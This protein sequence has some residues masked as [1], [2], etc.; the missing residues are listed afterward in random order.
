LYDNEDTQESN[1]TIRQNL[2]S[3]FD[4]TPLKA[5]R[6]DPPRTL[7]MTTQSNDSRV[8]RQE[9]DL[10]SAECMSLKAS[11]TNLEKSLSAA[12]LA[13]RE[14]TI[15]HER[16]L[17]KM[18]SEREREVAK[19]QEIR[20]KL[21]YV[22]E[23]ERHARE[24]IVELEIEMAAEK[25]NLDRKVM[26]AQRI[27]REAEDHAQ[28]QKDSWHETESSLH[29]Q[30]VAQKKELISVNSLYGESQAQ[31][32]LRGQRD[33]G[34]AVHLQ[35]VD[36]L[37]TQLKAAQDRA[38]ALESQLTDHEDNL[39]VTK[40]LKADLDLV[41]QM[42][43][44]LERLRLDNE[45]LKYNEQNC[46]LLEEEVRSL[47]GRLERAEDDNKQVVEL[48][49]ENE[50]LKGRL[51]RWEA[52]DESGSR[53]PQSPSSLSRRATDLETTI[54]VLTVQ[55]GELQTQINSARLRQQ[56][57]QSELHKLT[58]NLEQERSSK[59]Q[60]TE[61][62]K[63]LKRKVLFLSKERDCFKELVNSYESELTINVDAQKQVLWDKQEDILQDYRKQVMELETE[64]GKLEA[65]LADMHG[66]LSQQKLKPSASHPDNA[67][68]MTDLR[69]AQGKTA[70]V[71]LLLSK[72]QEE[73]SVLELRL[74]QRHL[75]GDFDPSKTK[76]LH[77]SFNPAAVAQER[78]E[79]ELET[80]RKEVETL[81]K[82]AQLLEENGGAAQDLTMQVEE[83][84][85]QPSPSKEL[86]E[87]KEKLHTEELRNK[88]L[89]E[90]FKKTSSEFREVCYQLTGYK[91]DI[92]CTNQYRLTNMYSESSRDHLLFQQKDGRIQV[93][94]TDYSSRL[95]ESLE[96]YL[97]RHNSI[98]ALLSS[99]TM[100]LFSQV[101]MLA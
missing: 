8:M 50:E 80:L 78:R 19:N 17:W 65:S 13:T 82:R 34:Q 61:L 91:I 87:I 5:R 85:L 68:L 53:R 41:P 45:Q 56:Q 95:Q 10:K 83:K 88:R 38:K 54:G 40:A 75:Q 96:L 98:P 20:S 6:M 58:L 77:F 11:I 66:K 16:Q 60:L 31:L 76:V 79:V 4:E 14:A 86:E 92:P 36:T 57:S 39:M 47:K 99:I 12:E 81:R 93:L 49:V 52:S 28:M 55:E 32:T 43:N 3:N 35:E 25:R 100:D 9:V 64:V 70:E 69:L 30:I 97:E 18:R 67:S 21:Q 24:K 37:R 73:K 1:H 62:I 22:M 59:A 94:E 90:I 72:V 89:K 84:L 15:E 26:E 74:E 2:L 44:D 23:Q 29:N 51:Q 71:E 63:K 101:T 7:S 48:E 42:K 33:S 27:R 46:L